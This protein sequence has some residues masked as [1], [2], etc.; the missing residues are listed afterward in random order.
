MS[1]VSVRTAKNSSPAAMS[2]SNV[3]MGLSLEGVVDGFAELHQALLARQAWHRGAGLR[4][5]GRA[6]LQPEQNRVGLGIGLPPP[7]EGAGPSESAH[8][9]ADDAVLFRVSDH[10]HA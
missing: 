9:A 3:R 5:R 1:F 7:P 6:L 8:T 10:R 4:R 2:A